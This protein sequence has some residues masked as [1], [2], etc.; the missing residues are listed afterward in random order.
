MIQARLRLIRLSSFQAFAT[1]RGSEPSF[2]APAVWTGS[3][4][5]PGFPAKA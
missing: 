4:L 5:S 1:D 2:A 3:A